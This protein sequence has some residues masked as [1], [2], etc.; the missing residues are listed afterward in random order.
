MKKVLMRAVMSPFD[1]FDAFHLITENT[2]GK[3]L[4]NLIFPYSMCRTLMT[5]DTEIE[6]VADS[7]FKTIRN[8]IDYYNSEFSSFVLPYAN[9]FREKNE[10]NLNSAAELFKSLK[11]PCVVTGIGAQGKVDGSLE[12]SSSLDDAATNFVSSVLDKSSMIG[13]RGEVTGAYLKKLGFIE[14]KHFTVTGCPSMYLHGS[15]LPRFNIPELTPASRVS[16]NGKLT[17]PVRLAEFIAESMKQFDNYHYT[18]QVLEE[19]SPMYAGCPYPERKFKTIPKGY[20]TKPSDETY[21][22]DK[23]ISFTNVPSWLKYFEDKEFC[24]GSRIHGNIVGILGGVP[25]YIIVH[26]SRT[27]ELASYHNI[28]HSS[29]LDLREDTTIFDLYE[30]A[31]FTKIHSGHDKRFNHFIDFL[32]ENGLDHIY[33]GNDKGVVVDSPF[34]KKISSIPF[35]G[36]MHSLFTASPEEQAERIEKFF[37]YYHDRIIDLKGKVKAQ[38]NDSMNYKAK[39]ILKKALI[40]LGLYG[41]R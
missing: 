13:V 19:L 24:F 40:K 36:P 8:N 38:K 10:K 5:E 27:M 12:T 16:I 30:Q 21:L 17:L 23:G 6:T 9:Y 20:P 34:D 41:E 1:N 31:D 7:G 22:F 3:N 29:F 35:R 2:I 11:I 15:S 26:D 39:S 4:G 33:R 28:P 14:E 18:P 25:S 32:D 37:M